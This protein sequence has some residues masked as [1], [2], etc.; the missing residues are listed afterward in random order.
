[1]WIIVDDHLVNIDH[2][3]AITPDAD[4]LTITIEF[5]TDV[6]VIKY[7]DVQTLIKDLQT[8][9]EKTGASSLSGKIVSAGDTDGIN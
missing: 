5:N 2:A 3:D 6:I 8:L 4:V 7:D 1:M 9:A